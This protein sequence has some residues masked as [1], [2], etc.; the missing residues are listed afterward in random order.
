MLFVVFIM[1]KAQGYVMKNL[2][3]PQAQV[4]HEYNYYYCH[5]FQERLQKKTQMVNY[6]MKS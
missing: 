5:H 3:G 6:D 1:G 2:K 4:V